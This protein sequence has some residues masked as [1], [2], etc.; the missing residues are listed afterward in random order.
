MAVKLAALRAGYQPFTT[1]SI[2]STH[3][4]YMVS[5]LKALVRLEESRKSKISVTSLG[6]ET[7][8]FLL[9]A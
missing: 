5:R 3:F 2:P 8:T 9:V 4:C 1:R 6:I 7:A